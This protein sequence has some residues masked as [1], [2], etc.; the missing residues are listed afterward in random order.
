MLLTILV[1]ITILAYTRRLWGPALLRFFIAQVAKR[2]QE[3]TGQQRNT[4]RYDEGETSIYKKAK[5][6]KRNVRKK[7][8]P[9]EYINFE[10]I[11]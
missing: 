4:Q 1:V 6:K 10:E 8:P 11:D 2:A 5:A 7:S 9:G 3:S